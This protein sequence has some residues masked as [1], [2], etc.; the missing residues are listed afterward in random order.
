[1]GLKIC[2]STWVK[3]K[4][5]VYLVSISAGDKEKNTLVIKKI[6][7]METLFVFFECTIVNLATYRQF[8][9]AA[10]DWIIIK[11]K[12]KKTKKQNKTKTTTTTTTITKIKSEL[13]QVWAIPV[14]FSTTKD[15]ICYSNGHIYHFLDYIKFLLFFNANVIHHV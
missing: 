14:P 6:I 9:S 11:K 10:W 7:I 12:N 13:H 5:A 15:V 8:T 4:Q 3:K 2:T 1:M